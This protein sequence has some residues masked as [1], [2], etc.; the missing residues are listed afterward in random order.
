[1]RFAILKSIFVLI[2]VGAGTP[3]DYFKSRVLSDLNALVE[4]ALPSPQQALLIKQTRHLVHRLAESNR[5][6]PI[7]ALF[8]FTAES[9][10]TLP[11][12]ELTLLNNIV[13]S[14]LEVAPIRPEIIVTQLAAGVRLN[15]DL[16]LLQIPGFFEDAGKQDAL[17]RILA[18][19]A[20]Y[21][22]EQEPKFKW[23]LEKDKD[24][25]S[26]I[27]HTM[28]LMGTIVAKVSEEHQMSVMDTFLGT[29]ICNG[30]QGTTKEER[31]QYLDEL[32]RMIQDP[33]T[34]EVAVRWAKLSVQAERFLKAYPELPPSVLFRSTRTTFDV[35]RYNK[36]AD[37]LEA[38]ARFPG[39]LP[40]DVIE[41]AR[42]AFWMAT[43]PSAENFSYTVADVMAYCATEPA[44]P[45]QEPAPVN[46][47]S[48]FAK[49]ALLHDLHL[50]T[51][52]PVLMHIR[53][54]PEVEA[55]SAKFAD[56][57][58]DLVRGLSETVSSPAEL[59]RIRR[60][61]GRKSV[62]GA[63]AVRDLYIHLVRLVHRFAQE[64]GHRVLVSHADMVRAAFPALT[65]GSIAHLR[66][67]IASLMAVN[68]EGDAGH[69][70]A[71]AM[72][73]QELGPIR[74]AAEGMAKAY[75]QFHQ[76]G[77]SLAIEFLPLGIQVAGPTIVNEWLAK[78]PGIT[79]FRRSA[80]RGPLAGIRSL[81]NDWNTPVS[82]TQ[83]DLESFMTTPKFIA[84]FSRDY[85]P[86]W[87]RFGIHLPR[88]VFL[89]QLFQA[90]QND[91]AAR[92]AKRRVVT[93]WIDIIETLFRHPIETIAHA[94]R[95]SLRDL[96]FSLTRRLNAFE[97]GRRTNS[98]TAADYEPI[99]DQIATL[100]KRIRGEV[101]PTTTSEPTSTSAESM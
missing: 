18:A 37:M 78:N 74:N 21:C 73:E 68:F 20:I 62:F 38:L 97:P 15:L 101:D 17:S 45:I 13:K 60:V 69:Y 93:V 83:I 10:R 39:E 55:Q 3:I 66:M 84:V 89:S 64:I 94:D 23:L 82:D 9:Y 51:S 4:A 70:V 65:E 52:P 16:D 35:E 2:A 5:P 71:G 32:E 1:M 92:D 44:L 95:K 81:I 27:A 41:S 86:D 33:A 56:L 28:E 100:L 87:A 57:L 40:E 7:E 67:I 88:A 24:E 76:E 54:T 63:R 53:M 42:E 80:L 98:Y 59:A 14:V 90:D 25:L 34:A 49:L 50:V 26:R 12:R 22:Q 31:M 11:N 46:T 8:R 48:S 75:R 79:V 36:V 43:D 29:S 77:D 19:H 99:F 96:F 72:T 58:N 6:E 85:V 91:R 30:P 47:S 61:L